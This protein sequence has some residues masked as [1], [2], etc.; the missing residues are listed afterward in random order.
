MA[1]KFL[2]VANNFIYPVVYLL[3]DY[4]NV[5]RHAS[6]LAK[7]LYSLSV[8]L[9]CAQNHWELARMSQECFNLFERLSN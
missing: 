5:S 6:L 4:K 8:M 1:N 2:A 3:Q 7:G 9:D